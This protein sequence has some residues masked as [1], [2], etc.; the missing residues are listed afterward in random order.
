MTTSD[1]KRP[2]FPPR[3]RLL[4]GIVLL[5]IAVGLTWAQWYSLQGP[6]ETLAWFEKNRA[7]GDSL[8]YA[9]TLYHASH[10]QATHANRWS[11][12]GYL[13]LGVIGVVV[14]L[15]LIASSSVGRVAPAE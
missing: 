2:F 8:A 9:S 7:P 11:P 1:A 4:L 6:M 3:S 5:V 15:T 10:A 12:T 13:T 14:A